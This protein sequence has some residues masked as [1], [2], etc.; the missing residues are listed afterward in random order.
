[1]IGTDIVGSGCTPQQGVIRVDRWDRIARRNRR[2]K[3]DIL[4]SNKGGLVGSG[5][6]PQQGVIRV[7]VHIV[8]C[9]MV[10]SGCTLHQFIVY[11]FFLYCDFI[12][13]YCNSFKDWL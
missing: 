12:L 7:N 13:E 3:G 8:T 4:R 9:Y 10:G 2:N 6:T 5:C 1:V 11:V